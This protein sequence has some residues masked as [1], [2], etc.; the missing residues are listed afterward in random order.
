[1][2]RLRSRPLPHRALAY[3]A[4]AALACAMPAVAQPSTRIVDCDAG[5]CLLV[6]GRRSDAS[7]PVRING[8]AVMTRGARQ[9]TA[10]VPVDAIR[11]W[12]SPRARSITVSVGD[13]Q[14]QAA[15]PI[16][17]LGRPEQLAFVTVTAK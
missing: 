8:R 12:A 11:R 6:T 5:S 9:W 16:G 13:D 2:T 15:L 14:L 7:V 4:L 17:M 1:M 3:G 10:S